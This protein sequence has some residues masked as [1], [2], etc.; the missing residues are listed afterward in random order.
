[1]K[2]VLIGLLFLGLTSLAYA[3]DKPANAD[4]DADV[5]EVKL[6]GVTVKNMNSNYLNKV[7]DPTTPERVVQLEN[8]AARYDLTTSDIYDGNH[9]AYEVIFEQTNGKII[10]TYN[11]DGQILTSFEKFTD[12]T[13]PA[14]VRNSLYKEYP[15]WTVHK[16]AYLVSY[17]EGTDTV[18]KLY[19]IQLRKEN[20]K[21]NLKCDVDGNIL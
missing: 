6:S 7:Q 16:D 10:A 14:P 2:K 12:L 20:Q 13:L 11:K 17:Y 4:K 3:Q 1:M 5:E 8:T 15:G 19:R 21:L 18:K 9:E